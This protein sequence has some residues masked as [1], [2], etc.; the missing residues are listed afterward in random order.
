MALDAIDGAAV[1]QRDNQMQASAVVPNG[2]IVIV[3]D[4]V[5]NDAQDFNFNLTNGTT[6]NQNFQ[7]DDDSDAT[8]P[9]SQTFSVPPGTWSAS[10]VFPLPATWA[11]T[12][13]VCVD[14]TSNTTVNVGTGIASINLASAET[15]SCTFTNSRDDRG[16]LRILKTLSNP[17]GAAV[18]A[19]FTVNYD[20]G[21]GYTGSVPVAAG[22]SATVSNIP[23]GRSCTVSEAT[24]TPIAGYTWGTPAITGSPA[25]I[26]KNTT[27]DVTVA[28][29]ISRDQG[30]LKI[31]K[32][33]DP[34]TSG[35]TGTFAITYNCGAGDQTVNVA[36]G[37][38]T[39]VGPFSTGTSCTVG[40]LTLPTAPTGWTFGTPVVSGSPATIVKGDP[41]A[42]VNVTV[43]NSISQNQGYLKI[44]K[45]F[46][47]K[48]SG[49]TGTFAI[50]YNCGVGNQTVNLAAGSWVTVGP[51]ATGTS[52]TVSEPT[53]PSAPAGWTFGTP[54]ISGSPAT[55]GKDTT[56]EATVTNS[57]SRDQGYLKISKVFDPKTSGFVGTFAIVYNCG[58]GNQAVNLAAGAST[59]VGPFDTGTS[60]T[61]SEPLLP[62]APTGWTFGTPSFSGSPATIA[63]GDQAAAITVT[64]TNTITRDPGYLKISKASTR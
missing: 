17:D 12:N 29:S 35:F 3:K 14:P 58:A 2:T 8:L 36:A 46:D 52:C 62:T 34:K 54:S 45:T 23:T 26:G 49:F 5:P 41:A 64:V 31:S 40:E 18:P 37:S 28:N 20:C 38:S 13:L 39:T 22:G 60:C 55:I 19:S 21:T 9:N 43:T 25:T 56:V 51:F 1:G 30:Y 57:I 4:A 16:S 53:L 42:A 59:T 63:K 24:L 48:T 10:E 27:V 32:V 61:V 11:L 7:L 50:I 6:I 47:P 33:F 15:V 44:S